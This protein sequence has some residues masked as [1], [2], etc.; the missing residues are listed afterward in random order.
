MGLE[1]SIEHKKEHRKEY[2]GSKRFDMSCRNH[3]TCEW[4]QNN[5][6]HST[7]VRLAKALEIEKENNNK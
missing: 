3:G 1:K 7:K 2:R 6:H 4:C 5:R